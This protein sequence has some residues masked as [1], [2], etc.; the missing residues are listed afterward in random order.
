MTRM[1][2]FLS[3]LVAAMFKNEAEPGVRLAQLESSVK[4]LVR[5]KSIPQTVQQCTSVLRSGWPLTRAPGGSS[6]VAAIAGSTKQQIGN[7]DRV[8]MLG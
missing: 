7:A 4:V 2:S 8:T 5:T 3:I 1:D 6:H